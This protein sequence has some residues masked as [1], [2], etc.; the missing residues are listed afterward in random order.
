[1]R[2]YFTKSIL[3]GLSNATISAIAAM[4]LIPLIIRNVGMEIYG[5]WTLVFIFV[6]LS[7]SLDIGIPKALVLLITKENNQDELNRLI[8]ASGCIMLVIVSLVVSFVFSLILADVHVWGKNTAISRS[9]SILLLLS[10]ANLVICGLVQSLCTG[11]L[12][13]RYKI[14]IINYISLF[15]TVFSYSLIFVISIFSSQVEKLLYG[16]NVVYI[17]ITIITIALT[18]KHCR[19]AFTRFNYSHVRQ[20]IIVG[21]D[22]FFMGLLFAITMPLMRYLVVFFSGDMVACGV[23]D[24]SLKIAMMASGLLSCFSIPL[25]SLFAGY[26]VKGIEK[27]KS[28]LSRVFVFLAVLMLIGLFIYMQVGEAILSFAF[29]TYDSRLFLTSLIL[30]SGIALCGL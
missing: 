8:S 15:L 22:F 11:I 23:Y 2:K 6:G 27:I 10:G 4:V 12:E 14:Y 13:A 28:V 16:T 7:A 30:L 24:V 5:A 3:S 1:M 21:K 19:T 25:F 26:G 20:I 18:K 29:E 9:L 17:L